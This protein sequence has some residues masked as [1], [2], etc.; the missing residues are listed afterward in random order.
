MLKK[1]AIIE[2]DVK[3]EFKYVRPLG[4]GGTGDIHLFKDETTDI[5]FAIK[6]YNPKNKSRID[7][8]YLR[9]VDEIKILFKIAHPNIVRIYN[10][11]LYPS[12]KIGYLQME[13]VE[14]I[15]I[16]KYDIEFWDKQWDEIFKDLVSAFQ[17]LE[18]NNILHRDIRPANFLIDSKG[19]VKII[20]FGFGKHIKPD[21]SDENSILLNWP[22][23]ELP[24]EVV[25]NHDYNH[26]TEI[27]FLGKLFKKLLG[28]DIK[29]FKFVQVLNSMIK[30]SPEERIKSFENVLYALSKG[31]LAEIEFTNDEKKLYQEFADNLISHISKFKSDVKYIEDINDIIQALS[32]LIRD[33]SLETHIQSNSK[34]IQ[35]FVTGSLSYHTS[36]DIEVECIKNFYEFFLNQ[37]QPNKEIII[38]NI[39]NRFS[40]IPVEISDDDLPF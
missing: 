33:N 38:Y 8:L 2:F 34:F 17:Y 28:D 10:Y 6:K 22:V 37:N 16:D 24:D 26:Q 30:T 27:Y 18:K 9:F 31:L 14:G 32:E 36:Q 29:D 3:K 19:N 4:K 11:Y 5:L 7:D 25:Q 15:E 12:D 13:F 23:S 20:D 1:D 39:H 35:C 40:E 21:E